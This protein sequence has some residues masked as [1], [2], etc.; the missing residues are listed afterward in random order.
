MLRGVSVGKI[1]LQS[2]EVF[3]I[4]LRRGQHGP[5]LLVVCGSTHMLCA[6]GVHAEV[7][8]TIGATKDT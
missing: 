7:S 8:S 1:L 6:H 2:F 4:G 3:L 5:L